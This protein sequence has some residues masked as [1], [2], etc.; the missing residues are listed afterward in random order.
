MASERPWLA[1]SSGLEQPSWGQRLQAGCSLCWEQLCGNWDVDC[2][3]ETGRTRRGL[4]SGGEQSRVELM[5][6]KSTC[7]V[8]SDFKAGRITHTHFSTGGLPILS[9]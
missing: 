9:G 6:R 7:E 4:S 5:G 1:R 8:G 3:Y 2:D